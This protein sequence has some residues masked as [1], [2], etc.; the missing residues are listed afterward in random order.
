MEER[1]LQ[2]GDG[3]YCA[4]LLL[5]PLSLTNTYNSRIFILEG[6]ITCA[7]GILAYF[8]IVKFPD[9]EMAKP[10][11]F[12]LKPDEVKAVIS[13]LE[14]D[15]GDVD[16]EPFQWKRFVAPARHFEIWVFAFLFL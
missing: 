12:F 10:S 14:A 7:V 6:V 2:D 4:R 1:D 5:L 16:A 3:S 15:R 9:E 8:L 13:R 11:L